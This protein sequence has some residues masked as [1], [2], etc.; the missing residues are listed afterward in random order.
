MNLANLKISGKLSA[1]FAL[2][3][4]VFIIDAGVLFSALNTTL[5]MAR[6]NN[7]SYL[8]S[9]DVNA[10]LQD[11]VEQQNAT[12][13]EIAASIQDAATNTAQASVE[14]RSVE[15][16]AGRNVAALSDIAGWTA[17]LSSRADDLQAK[18]AE[19]FSRVRAA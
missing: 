13:H 5:D 18:V 1:A 19:F 4:A 14:C 11:A 6:K 9:K 16:A 7:V 15:D 3:L 8:N 12:T 17:R 10:V 2:I